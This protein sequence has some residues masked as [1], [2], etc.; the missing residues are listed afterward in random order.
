M[1]RYKELRRRERAVAEK[2]KG[3]LD[4]AL[5]WCEMRLAM[6]TTKHGEKTWMRLIKRVRSALDEIGN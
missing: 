5:S 4:W 6:A 3:E 2:N 1:T